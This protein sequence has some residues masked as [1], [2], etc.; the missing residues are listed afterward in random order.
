M[1][2]RTHNDRVEAFAFVRRLSVAKLRRPRYCSLCS[3]ATH[4][5]VLFACV[6]GSLGIL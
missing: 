3:D 6:I 2:Q 4:R 5:A 1:S